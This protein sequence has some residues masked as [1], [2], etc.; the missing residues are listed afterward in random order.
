MVQDV[1]DALRELA[2]VDVATM[3]GLAENVEFRLPPELAQAP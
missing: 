2:P 3:E 1:I